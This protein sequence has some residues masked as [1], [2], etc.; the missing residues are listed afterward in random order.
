MLTNI[1]KWK[2]QEVMKNKMGRAEIKEIKTLEIIELIQII[3]DRSKWKKMV[4][5]MKE[6]SSFKIRW[7]NVCGMTPLLL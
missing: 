7:K 4:N 6:N 1:I 3:K 5:E 2:P